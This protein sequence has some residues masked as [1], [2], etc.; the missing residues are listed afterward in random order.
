MHGIT[1]DNYPL[2]INDFLI[3]TTNKKSV[4]ELLNIPYEC[5]LQAFVLRFQLSK[6]LYN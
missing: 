2:F 4:T 3:H 6:L 5:L 1:D